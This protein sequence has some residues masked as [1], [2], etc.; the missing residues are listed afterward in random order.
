ML[1]RDDGFGYAVAARL[2]DLPAGAELLETGIGGVALLQELMQGCDGLIIVDAVDRGTEPGTVFLI[3]P[4]IG[5]PSGVPDM[6]LANPDQVLAM[7]KAMGCL[8][9]RVLRVGCQPG[10]EGLGE[11]L[12]P[13]VSRAVD[14]AAERVRETLAGWVGRTDPDR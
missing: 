1:R 10:D 13:P 6:H 5:E 9:G 12:T 14:V 11:E 4:D 8:P 7:A 2:R 3:E